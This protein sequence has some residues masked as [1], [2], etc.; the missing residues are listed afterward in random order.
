M[1]Q[2]FNLFLSNLSVCFADSRSPSGTNVPSP[3]AGGVFPS[4]GA[5]GKEMNY[6][7]NLLSLLVAQSVPTDWNACTSRISSTTQT[8]MILVW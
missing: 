3:P 7:L 1:E 4:R 5:F 2:P 6:F 8:I